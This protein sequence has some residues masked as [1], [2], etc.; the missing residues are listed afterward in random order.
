MLGLAKGPEVRLG[1]FGN[2][3]SGGQSFLVYPWKAG[4]TYRF[5]TEVKPDGNGNTRYTCWFGP[6]D[7][8]FRLIASFL[9]SQDE[10]YAER[11]SFLSGKLCTRDWQS[12]QARFLW[13]CVGA[14]HQRQVA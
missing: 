10:Y 13:Q 12:N 2:E 6:K 14:R 11:I 9:A 5:L 4:M 1:E 7:G 8:E 3:G